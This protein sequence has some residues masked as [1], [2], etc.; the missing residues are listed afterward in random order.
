VIVGNREVVLSAQHQQ[1]PQAKK[2]G[3]GRW[4]I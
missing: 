2:E 3:I 4:L 1:Y